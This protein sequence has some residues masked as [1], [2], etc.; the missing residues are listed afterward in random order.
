MLLKSAGSVVTQVS[1]V[2]SIAVTWDL[3]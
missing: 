3:P 2:V 1:A